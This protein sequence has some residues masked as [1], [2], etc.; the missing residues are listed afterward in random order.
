M[1]LIQTNCFTDAV[2]D[3]LLAFLGHQN[4][5][6]LR[7][8]EWPGAR[9]TPTEPCESC[10]QRDFREIAK[11]FQQRIVVSRNDMDAVRVLR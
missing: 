7:L 11:H 9:L 10:V 6:V 5:A 4:T 8:E 1:R 3:L 2:I